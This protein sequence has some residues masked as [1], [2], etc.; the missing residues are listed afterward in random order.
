ML[1]KAGRELFA[2]ARACTRS[3]IRGATVRP[4]VSA[5]RFG[6]GRCL[7]GRSDASTARR[8]QC[9]C[10]SETVSAAVTEPVTASV[11]EPT[12]RQLR[13]HFCWQAVPMVGFG[14]MDQ[15]VLIHAGNAIDCTLGVMFGLSTLT[16]AAIGSI[17]SMLV[18]LATGGTVE[19][20]AM[21]LGLPAPGI[22]TAQ[23]ALRIVHRVGIA[24]T[25]A[26]ALLGCSIGML[27]LLFV[28]TSRAEVLK[29][30]AI[31]QDQEM[32]FE[33]ET[34]N[35]LRPDATAITVRGPDVDG[36]LASMTAAVASAGYS[37]VELHATTLQPVGAG[38][39]PSSST[40]MSE[41]T[42]IVRPRGSKTEQVPD[43][44]LDGLAR[45]VLAACKD[46]L[47]A[48]TLKT[49]VQNLKEDNDALLQRVSWLERALVDRQIKIEYNRPKRD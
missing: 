2:R 12:Q 21:H 6:I 20:A 43:G 44:E 16:A 31:T 22:S 41:D 47:S 18:G 9:R 30:R 19:R 11:A 49:Q 29:L 25:L 35:R 24:G 40:H 10:L 13:R 48:R 15:T 4:S 7:D 23:R 42:F 32:A 33:V 39:S 14:F 45:A 27:N 17:C 26:G 36:T 34:S 46:P 37:V 38:D 8:C 5:A 3:S 1:S 28:D